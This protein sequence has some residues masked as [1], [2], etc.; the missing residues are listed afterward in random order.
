M[1]LI[2]G[3]RVS[4]RLF[5]DIDHFKAVCSKRISYVR[6]GVDVAAMRLD[7]ITMRHVRFSNRMLEREEKASARSQRTVRRREHFPK[8]A[9]VNERVGRGDHV[10]SGG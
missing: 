10:E 9:E 3:S 2:H 8:V 5:L 6:L 4:E 7:A 1:L